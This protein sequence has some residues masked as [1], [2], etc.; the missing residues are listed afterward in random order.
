MACHALLR[1]WRGGEVEGKCATRSWFLG[2]V[3]SDQLT[4]Q[5]NIVKIRETFLP[6][7]YLAGGV[8]CKNQIIC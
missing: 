3:P 1:P 7:I 6:I 8:V 4:D 2:Y 5:R